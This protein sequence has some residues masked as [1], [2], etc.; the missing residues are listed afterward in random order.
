MNKNLYS[1]TELLTLMA[2]MAIIIHLAFE[3]IDSLYAKASQI[4]CQSHLKNI[5]IATNAYTV[6]Y[7]DRLPHEDKGGHLPPHDSAWTQVLGISPFE[8]SIGDGS[9]G[10]NLK[11]NSRLED[12]RGTKERPSDSFRHLPN[13]P[14]PQSTPYIFDGRFDN[15][16]QDKMYGSPSSVE[17]RHDLE[18]NFLFLDGSVKGLFER[19]KPKGGWSGHG[20]LLWDPDV[21]L[22]KQRL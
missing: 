7:G 14:S 1:L 10:Y 11:M 16:Y 22:E 15:W 5:W 18:S 2:C 12:F 13:L 4:H 20:N 21:D 9:I 8:M 19:P 6:N 3:T 17:P